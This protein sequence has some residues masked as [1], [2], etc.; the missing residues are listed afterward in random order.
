MH[1]HGQDH[2]GRNPVEGVGAEEEQQ[3]PVGG[4]EAGGALHGLHPQKEESE[5]DDPVPEVALPFRPAEKG[6]GD[7]QGDEGEGEVVDLEGDDLGRHGC[8]DVRPHDDADGLLQGHQ[9]GIDEADGHHG[10]SAAALD[11]DRD[12]NPHEDAAER[13]LRQRPDQVAHTVPRYELQGLAHQLDSVEK[14]A[15]AAGCVKQYG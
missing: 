12:E 6:Q 10:R 13:R 4:H 5:A 8:A 14:K 9:P 15:Y 3:F 1:D 11:E 7:P 2:A